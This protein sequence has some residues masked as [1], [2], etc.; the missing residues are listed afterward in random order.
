MTENTLRARLA[1]PPILVAPGVYDPLTALIAEQA[2]QRG[3]ARCDHR[4]ELEG[5]MEQ[6]HAA[7]VEAQRRVVR[8][9][10]QFDAEQAARREARGLA[11]E[12]RQ[13]APAL[14][15]VPDRGAAGRPTFERLLDRRQHARVLGL[16]GL[17]GGIDQHQPAFLGGR[18]QG[19]QQGVAV[20][21][22][23]HGATL[24]GQRRA[25]SL[26]IAI[27][28]P[29]GCN[30]K[31]HTDRDRQLAEKYI[32]LWGLVESDEDDGGAEPESA[33]EL[34]AAV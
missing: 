21:L 13:A 5:R 7:A 12:G 17:V 16:L 19:A 4:I 20:A 31:S 11:E 25:K 28:T 22:V 6:Q 27:T 1:R 26:V 33:P 3:Q 10:Q 23:D 14:D 18:Q 9:D 29:N 8:A 2:G 32:R 15:R 30:I 24:A 34:T